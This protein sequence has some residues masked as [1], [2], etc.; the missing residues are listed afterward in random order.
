MSPGVW[1]EEDTDLHV[2]NRLSAGR[3]A[4]ESCEGT[5]LLPRSA[6]DRVDQPVVLG[7]DGIEISP[8]SH[9]VRDLVDRPPRGSREMRLEPHEQVQ[10]LPRPGVDLVRCSGEAH[11]GL[12]DPEPRVRPGGALTGCSH[13]TDRRRADLPSTPGTHRSPDRAERIDEHE[14]GLER[15]VRAVHVDLDRGVA[16]RI[17]AHE[18]GAVRAATASS[19]HP[20]TS[21]MRRS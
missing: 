14:S 21:T 19:S 13:D 15:A 20:V 7:F 18:R 3:R 1:N 12:S 16:R 9:V 8:P 5:G 11:V 6:A 10:V 2:V 4:T 17:Q